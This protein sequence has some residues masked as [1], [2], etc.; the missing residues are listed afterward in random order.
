MMISAESPQ[1]SSRIWIIRYC[2]KKRS[3]TTP[4]VISPRLLIAACTERKSPMKKYRYY[5]IPFIVFPLAGAFCSVLRYT[6]IVKMNFNIWAI[7][8]ALASVVIGNLS[9]TNKIF[10]FAI[11]VVSVIAYN[12]YRFVFGF[13]AKTDTETRFSIFEAIEWIFVDTSLLLCVM[14]AL[15]TFLASFRPIRI[16]RV[17]KRNKKC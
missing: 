2:P 16:L 12:C 13:L 6:G 3:A 17:L 10:D 1:E 14:C 5:I 15:I 11:P 8:F 4:Q 9:P 7:V